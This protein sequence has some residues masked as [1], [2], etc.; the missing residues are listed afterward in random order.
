MRCTT[1]DVERR[2][3]M[4][5]SKVPVGELPDSCS[6]RK[7][8]CTVCCCA[9]HCEFSLHLPSRMKTLEVSLEFQADHIVVDDLG[10]LEDETKFNG[11][12]LQV[13]MWQI[14]NS[15]DIDMNML[16]H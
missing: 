11:G 8:K 4:V 9:S 7:V 6:K 12:D 16:F 14:L 10:L 1:A 3:G 5:S 13:D 15:V 2:L